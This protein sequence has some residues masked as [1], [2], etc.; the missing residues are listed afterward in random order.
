MK[1]CALLCVHHG[2]MTKMLSGYRPFSNH[3]CMYV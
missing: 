3:Y 2:Q 1:L